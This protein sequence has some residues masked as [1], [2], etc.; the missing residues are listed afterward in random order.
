MP[1][2]R[3]IHCADLHLEAPFTGVHFEDNQTWKSYSNATFDAFQKVIQTAIQQK[4]DFVLIAGDIYNSTNKSLRAQLFFLK[5]MKLLSDNNIPCF[6]VHGNHD[7]MDGWE[8]PMKF[9][10]NIHRFGST[11]SHETIKKNGVPVVNIIGYSYPTRDIQ[12]NIAMEMVAYA[13]QIPNEAFTIGLLHCNVGADSSTENYAPCNLSD[14][15]DSP[16]HYWA[17]GHVHTRKVLHDASPYVVYPGNTQGLH[18]NDTKQKGFYLNTVTDNE[19]R[20]DFIPTSQFEW[21]HESLNVTDESIDDITETI[22]QDMTSKTEIL[23]GIF[24]YVLTGRSSFHST[25]RNQKEEIETSIR[26]NID[27]ENCLLESIRIQTKPNIDLDSIRDRNDFSSIFLKNTEEVLQCD[28]KEVKAKELLDDFPLNKLFSIL[29]DKGASIDWESITNE[30][31]LIGLDY[32]LE[33][34]NE[35]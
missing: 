28:E 2:K 14:L 20:L 29:P 9:P 3:F 18:I 21:Y 16:V 12:S 35:N 7:P 23:P 24:R 25:L 4:V 15:V 19:V 17:L 27:G 22:I 5:Q 13:K 31:Q 33:G 32:L 26:D 34:D 1:T 11:V 6:I 30:A 8:V 10:P